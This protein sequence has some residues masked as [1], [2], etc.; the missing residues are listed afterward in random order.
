MKLL[1]NSLED[2]ET[3]DKQSPDQKFIFG[4]GRYSREA[5]AL[6]EF[7][8]YVEEN[9]SQTSMFGK[10]TRTLNSIPEGSSILVGS[11]LYP[12][13]ASAK[14]REKGLRPIHLLFYLNVRLQKRIYFHDF[15]HHFEQN[16]ESYSRL[17]QFLNDQESKNLLTAIIDFRLTADINRLWEMKSLGEHYFET[18]LQLENNEF[19]L[20]IGSY[21]GENTLR[22]LEKTRGD[23]K[24]LMFEAN[25][26]QKVILDSLCKRNAK[27][28]FFMGALSDKDSYLDF[29]P[30][31][32]T[33][34]RLQ[35]FASETSIRIPGRKLDSLDLGGA[36]TLI[37]LDI[38]GAEMRVLRGAIKT[39][40]KY[41][42]KL[43]VSVYHKYSDIAEVFNFCQE[44]LPN[45]E[46]YLRQYTEG[47]DEIVLYCL[48]Q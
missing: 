16:H 43:A 9:P 37:K 18:F 22:F 15:K 21:D 42:P 41:R 38:E 6:M 40:R 13:S 26:N 17:H 20:D 45:S 2:V 14:L 29:E 23:G 48:P 3:F 33:S 30:S 4:T 12:F 11:S 28:G 39:I 19:F 7:D 5:I 27:L 36:P 24:A 32:G 46:Y 31:L 47:T 10:P 8:S 1:D 44:H 34:S 35:D 25:P